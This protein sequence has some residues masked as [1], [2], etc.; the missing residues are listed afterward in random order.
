MFLRGTT[1]RGCEEP[2]ERAEPGTDRVAWVNG[3]QR[4]AAR[5]L[6]FYATHNV[7]TSMWSYS[8]RD[9]CLPA[10][11]EA[12]LLDMRNLVRRLRVQRGGRSFP[13]AFVAEGGRAG[14]RLNAH[15]LLAGWWDHQAME[16]AW[17]RGWVWVSKPRGDQGEREAAR[18]N[19]RYVAK[20][21]GKEMLRAGP[22]KQR[23]RVG[24][25]FR[26][27]EDRLWA[28]AP[29]TAIRKAAAALG[30]TVDRLWASDSDPEWEGPP[31]YWLRAP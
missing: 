26:W 15:M 14:T 4:R 28:P 10:G 27:P 13:Y 24:E 20:Y 17:G 23:Y 9:D 31:T 12:A 3:N 6:R 5:R 21:A 25:G 30:G 7:L 1:V 18:A 11:P 8:W 16:A 29:G 22:G 2:P 19:A